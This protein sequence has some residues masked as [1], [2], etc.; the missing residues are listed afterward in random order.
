MTNPGLTIVE[1]EIRTVLA[2]AEAN[3]AIDRG[4]SV[5]TPDVLSISPNLRAQR[6]AAVFVFRCRLAGSIRRVEIE[7][8][9]SV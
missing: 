1:N 8:Y 7:G 5:T 4:W 6:T 9:L 3:G 2:Q